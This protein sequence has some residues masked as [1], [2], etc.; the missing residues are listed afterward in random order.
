MH[1]DFAALD[2]RI[3]YKLLTATV[4]PR[5]VAWVTTLD[6]DGVVNAAPF[7]FFNVFSEDPALVILG[8]QHR[9][10]RSAKDTTRN[11]AESGEFVVNI[12]NAALLD[13]M[14]ATA[15]PYSP[16]ISEPDSLGIA[17]APSVLVGPPRIAE[18]PVA[19]EC[20]R[21]TSLAFGPE[22]EIMIGEVL[23]LHARDGLIDEAT[24]RV[25]WKGDLPVARLY[26]DRYA[27]VETELSRPIPDPVTRPEQGNTK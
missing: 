12:A 18:A 26:G 3:R 21:H 13:R 14:V 25:E 16:G 27:L 1:I 22:R 2:P 6:R 8:L 5:P 17:T 10:D 9:P 4:I 7:S 23:A 19:L 20:R 24:W 11:I 15:S